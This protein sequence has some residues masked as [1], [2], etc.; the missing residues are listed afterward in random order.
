[1]ALDREF[2][3]WLDILPAEIARFSERAHFFGRRGKF[4]DAG[5]EAPVEE[6]GKRAIPHRLEVGHVD[7]ILADERLDFGSAPARALIKS[8]QP[9]IDRLRFDP[10]RKRT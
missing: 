6:F 7:V 1:M 3:T 2:L 5:T 10:L 8:V 9:V 4:S